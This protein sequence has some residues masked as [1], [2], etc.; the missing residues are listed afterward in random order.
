MHL[1]QKC[2]FDLIV[3]FRVGDIIST[4]LHLGHSSLSNKRW[5][6]PSR[7][8][9]RIRLEASGGVTLRPVSSPRRNSSFFTFSVNLLHFLALRAQPR[10]T[11]LELLAVEALEVLS[12]SGILAFREEHFAAHCRLMWP[13]CVSRWSF[14]WCLPK[15]RWFIR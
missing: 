7:H 6:V 13:Y 4:S 8:I 12:V 15:S 2:W 10:G 3:F 1:S 5:L 9:V 14:Y 11:L